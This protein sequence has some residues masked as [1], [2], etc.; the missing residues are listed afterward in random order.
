LDDEYDDIR[1]ETS[2]HMIVI[3]GFTKREFIIVDSEHLF[4]KWK[5]IIKRTF[6]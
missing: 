2:G 6:A 5:G 1:G 4:D 3:R